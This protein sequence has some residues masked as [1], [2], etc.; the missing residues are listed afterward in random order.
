MLKSKLTSTV[1]AQANARLSHL[2]PLH[3]KHIEFGI[4]ALD[5]ITGPQI[6]AQ[7]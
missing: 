4:N 2:F 6:Q 1:I 5:S 7:H 3:V